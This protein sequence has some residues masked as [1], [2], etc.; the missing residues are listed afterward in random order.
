MAKKKRASL[1]AKPAKE[2]PCGK[3]FMGKGKKKKKGK[4]KAVKMKAAG[5]FRGDGCD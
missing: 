3:T 2:S 5:T 1:K 4:S